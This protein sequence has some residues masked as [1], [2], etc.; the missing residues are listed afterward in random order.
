MNDKL[1][2]GAYTSKCRNLN[3]WNS[4]QQIERGKQIEIQKGHIIDAEVGTLFLVCAV[5]SL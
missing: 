4:Q 2:Y 5:V 3:N 1:A